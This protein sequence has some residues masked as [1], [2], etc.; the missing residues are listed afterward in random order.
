MQHL[1]IGNFP[2]IWLEQSRSER[3]LLQLL[4]AYGNNS[5]SR[6]GRPVYFVLEGNVNPRDAE[7]RGLSLMYPNPQQSNFSY[8]S[9]HLWHQTS[10]LERLGFQSLT[11][12]SFCRTGWKIDLWLGE[13]ESCLQ[14]LRLRW[15]RLGQRTRRYGRAKTRNRYSFAQG[16]FCSIWKWKILDINCRNN[17][18]KQGEL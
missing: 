14:H 17:F 2:C 10:K 18:R 7:E 4:Q 9:Y 15:S 6:D 12:L 5:H 16:S 1:V 3:P 11:I 13:F 8:R